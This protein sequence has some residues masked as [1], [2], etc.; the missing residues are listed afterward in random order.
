MSVMVSSLHYPYGSDVSYDIYQKRYRDSI[1]ES[2]KVLIELIRSVIGGRSASLLDVG[3]STGNLLRHVKR[4]LPG[5]RLTGGDLS[6]SAIEQCRAD[7]ELSGVTFDFYN[8]LDLAGAGQ[9]DVI[10]AN[11]VAFS[12]D[13]S[14]YRQ[15]LASVFSALKPG[16]HYFAF[17]FL[18]S[19]ELQDV[20]IVET[21]DWHPQGIQ[22]C[23]RPMVKVRAL[24]TE[25]GF[26]KIEFY[27]FE[28]PIDLPFPGYEAH[29]STYTRKDE[30]GLRM[31]F[32]GILY[33]PWCH[34]VARKA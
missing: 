17:E 19:F 26:D 4:L 15:A 27:P 2:D 18:H 5:L 22:L 34:V 1:R 29:V 31:A 11:A 3:C 10:V 20:T 13:W 12:L 28:L 8:M 24:L 21:S 14:G 33:Q 6:K 23:F 9:F 16:G 30:H 25:L 7:P 32:R